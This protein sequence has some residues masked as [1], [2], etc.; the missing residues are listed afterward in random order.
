VPAIDQCQQ[1]VV[2][3]LEKDG[4]TLAASPE[5]VSNI[6][7]TVFVD[8]K[9]TRGVN[10]TREVIMLVEVKCFPDPKN[11]TPDLY[12]S[13]G[14]YLIYRAMLEVDG[15]FNNIFLT[16]PESIFEVNFDPI[17]MKVILENEIRIIVID[18]ENEVIVKWIR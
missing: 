5:T 13:I 6:Y 16:I 18:L 10:G 7:R 9:L 2:R 11:T 8:M 15:K 3:A 12:A 14:Q 4:W 1:Q 17:V